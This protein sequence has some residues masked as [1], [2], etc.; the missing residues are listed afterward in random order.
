MDTPKPPFIPMH[1]SPAGTWSWR[2]VPS[3]QLR[4]TRRLLIFASVVAVALN[5]AD[6]LIAGEYAATR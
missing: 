4:P 1:T 5:V 3:A 2:G 6:P